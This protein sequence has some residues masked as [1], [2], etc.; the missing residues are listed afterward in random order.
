[1]KVNKTFLFYALLLILGTLLSFRP[2]TD[3]DFGWHYKY[4]EYFVKNNRLLKNND[5][6]YTMPDYKWANSYWLT[7]VI[8]YS[9]GNKYGLIALSLVFSAVLSS[10]AL[11]ILGRVVENKTTLSAVFIIFL[12][13][14]GI[15]YL[16]V[17]PMIFSSIFLFVLLYVLIYKNSYIKFLPIMFLIWA[18]MHAGFTIGLF[19]FGI[20]VLEKIVTSKG[21]KTKLEPAFFFVICL[22]ATLINPYGISLWETLL[23][24]SNPLQF[25]HISEW[26]PF[27]YEL[28]NSTELVNFVSISFIL[29]FFFMSIIINGKRLG[30]WYLLVNL[31]LF[32]FSFRASYFLRVLVVSQIFGFASFV[33]KYYKE[34]SDGFKPK[35]ITQAGKLK[36]IFHLFVILVIV[37]LFLLNLKTALDPAFGDTKNSYPVEAIEYVKENE[38]KGNMF[39]NYNWGGYLIW[40]LPEYKTFIDG[41]MPSWRDG[42]EFVFHDYIDITKEPE[43]H[44]D[45]F[46][47]YVQRY[48]IGWIIYPSKGNLIDY[49]KNNPD[50]GW[51][52]VFE[53]EASIILLNSNLKQ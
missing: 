4:G 20:Y 29:A 34:F 19:V 14:I 43:N 25:S 40:K 6:S 33:D 21:A 11:L 49:L 39:N 5:F 7:Q 26:V 3:P 16:S 9:I 51:N 8:M 24:E 46:K 30:F 22:A 15:Y 23:K 41:R 12:S 28:E 42:K 47:E 35:I 52:V 53:N 18:N 48:K 32:T 38:L 50:L 1:M 17:R 44:I 2:A 37:E 13:I 10:I 27:S 45:L 31:V 36:P